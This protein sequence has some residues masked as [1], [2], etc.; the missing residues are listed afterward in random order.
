MQIAHKG[1]EAFFNAPAHPAGP[2]E[3]FKFKVYSA[4]SAA[5]VM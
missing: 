2:S 1:D 4:L 3:W 5:I